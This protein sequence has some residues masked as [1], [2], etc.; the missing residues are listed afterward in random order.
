MAQKSVASASKQYIGFM[1]GEQEFAAPIS[2]I[3]EIVEIPAITVVPNVKDYVVGVINLRGHVVP[4]VDLRKRLNLGE[5]Q[6]SLD[7]RII[8]FRVKSRTAGFI[9]NAITQV[10][11]LADIQIDTPSE[12]ML[13]KDEGKFIAGIAKLEHRL[14]ILLDIPKILEASKSEYAEKR[15]KLTQPV[16]SAEEKSAAG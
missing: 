9:V 4:V 3:Q 6:I 13:A 15:K 8:V 10:F 16:G 12:M 7:S 2:M 14:P 5:R 11:E 1:L